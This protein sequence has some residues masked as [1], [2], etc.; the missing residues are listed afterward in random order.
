MGVCALAWL[1]HRPGYRFSVGRVLAIYAGLMSA[2]LLAAVDHNCRRHGA[3][4]D[5]LGARRL[6]ELSVGLSNDDRGKDSGRRP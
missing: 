3:A 6:L 1:A 4:A 5:R 2:L